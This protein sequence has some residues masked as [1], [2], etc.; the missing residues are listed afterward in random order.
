MPYSAKAIAM[1]RC[2]HVRPDGRQCKAWAAWDDPG[3]RC[4][5]HAGRHHRGPM[6][7]PDERQAALQLEWEMGVEFFHRHAKTP[8]CRCVAYAWPHRPGGGLCR[9]PDPPEYRRTTPASTHKPGRLRPP[10]FMTRMG[11]HTVK[12]AERAFGF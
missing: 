4:N 2:T 3:Q 12:Q 6:L 9:W 5:I 8:P 10:R 1:R 7:G 11:I